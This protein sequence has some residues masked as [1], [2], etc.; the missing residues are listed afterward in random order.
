MCEKTDDMQS[1]NKGHEKP[2]DLTF[3]L[4]LRF[5]LHGEFCCLKSLSS[6]AWTFLCCKTALYNPANHFDLTNAD[7]YEVSLLL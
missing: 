4:G 7:Y 3:D 1:I 5:A 2:W 6:C